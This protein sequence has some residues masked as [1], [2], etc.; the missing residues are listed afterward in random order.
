MASRAGKAC[1]FG[2]EVD[3]RGLTER[4][5]CSKFITPALT[6]AGWDLQTQI[7]EEKS[8][9]A[10]RIIVRGR[11]HARG[12]RRRADYVLSYQKNQPIAV[13]EAKDNTHAPELCHSPPPSPAA[14]E[15]PEVCGVGGV[16]VPPVVQC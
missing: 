11:L 15:A 1:W 12:Q 13:I 6:R 2:G 16:K 7:R 3:K 5:I 4:D 14:E 9:T 8:F 10:G